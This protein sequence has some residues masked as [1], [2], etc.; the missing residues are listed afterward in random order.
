ME[1]V[2]VNK[3]RLGALIKQKRCNLKLTQKAISEAT[4]LSRSYIADI[5]AG[6]Y[7]PSVNSIYRIAKALELDLN[8]L[9][10]MTEIQVK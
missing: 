2:E 7:N 1:K 9:L 4:K 8:F 10:S 3:M 5:E 6:R